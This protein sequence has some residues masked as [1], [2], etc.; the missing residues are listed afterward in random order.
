MAKHMS[1]HAIIV[2]S[3]DGFDEFS[4]FFCLYDKG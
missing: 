2:F 1:T 3:I 4:E